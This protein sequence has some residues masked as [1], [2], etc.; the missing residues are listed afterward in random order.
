MLVDIAFGPSVTDKDKGLIPY[1][2]ISCT[3]KAGELVFA[4][5]RGLETLALHE[6][7]HSFVN[8]ALALYAERIDAFPPLAEDVREHMVAGGN[9]PLPRGFVVENVLRA[10]TSRAESELYGASLGRSRIA[11]HK[12]RGYYLVGLLTRDLDMYAGNRS[13]YP[14]FADFVPTLLDKIEDYR[15]MEGARWK[16][17]LMENWRTTVAVM[18]GAALLVAVVKLQSRWLA[19]N[20]PH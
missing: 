19:S 20:R 8:P 14:T 5:G 3:G 6:L 2:T 15:A 11:A 18:L 10:I 9:G 12:G 1:Q 13:K 17:W 16:L 4:S 7:G